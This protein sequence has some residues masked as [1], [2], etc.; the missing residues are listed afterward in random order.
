MIAGNTNTGSADG[1]TVSGESVTVNSDGNSAYALVPLTVVNN[2]GF[3]LPQTGAAG[4]AL[5]AIVGIVLAAVAGG[6]LFFLK[7]SPKRK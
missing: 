2:K 5:F 3:D 7:K 6:L 4:T 1:S